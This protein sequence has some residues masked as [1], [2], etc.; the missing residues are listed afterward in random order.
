MSEL[1]LTDRERHFWEDVYLVAVQNIESPAIYADSAIFH[2][3]ARI[4]AATDIAE[5]MLA[6]YVLKSDL[7]EA[8]L[9]ERERCAKIAEHYTLGCR[10]P[11]L[12][13]FVAGM[14]NSARSI[15]E[16]IKAGAKMPS[17]AD[18]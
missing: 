14:L 10:A 16:R 9:A 11:A 13:E 4:A 5:P 1:K 7:D 17:G 15:M 12:S 3:R 8:V 2:L 6:D 18:E